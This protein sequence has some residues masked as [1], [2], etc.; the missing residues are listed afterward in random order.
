[1]SCKTSRTVCGISGIFRASAEAPSIDALERM[2]SV[3]EHRGPDGYGVYRDEAVAL[4][5]TRLS[6]IDLEGGAQP[7][8]NE[9]GTVWLTFNG[10]IFDYPELRA[11]LKAAGHVFRTQTDSE[12]IVHAYEEWGEQAW[13]R[14]DG[15]FAFALWDTRRGLLW[16]VRDPM[17]ILPLHYVEDPGGLAFGSEA[18]ALFAGGFAAPSFDIASLGQ[19]F[20]RWSVRAPHTM[21]EGV[22]MV[23]PGAA[24]RIERD[25]RIETRPY[26]ELDFTT[27]PELADV[28]ATEA[29]EALDAALT[30]S[31]RIRLRADVPVGSYL[32]GGLDSSVIAQRARAVSADRLETFAVRF[33]DPAFD[34]TLHQ[35]RMAELL[36]TEHHEV[37]CESRDVADALPEVIWH[38]ETPLVRTAPVPLYH[39]SGLVRDSGRRVVLTG[40]GADE[41]FA[42]Y[43]IFK[44]SRVRRFWARQPESRA[45][46]ALLSRVYP[47]VPHGRGA[48]MWQAFFKKGFEAVEDPLYSHRIRWSNTQ[49]ILRFLSD[50]A[51]A[52]IDLEREEARLQESLPKGFARWSPLARAQ[53]LEI[54]G[55]MRTYLLAA[56][57]DR[58]AMGHSVEV[59]YPFLD[60]EVIRLA[61]RLP[62]RTKLLGLR[63]KLVLRRL[64]QRSLPDSIWARPKQPYRAPM[65]APFF[66]PGRPEY[67]EALT[68]E[69]AILDSGLFDPAATA[70]LF[71][72][73]RASEGRNVSER[74]QMAIVG[75][76]TLQLLARAYG[77]ELAG[78]LEV[79]RRR[80]EAQPRLVF[81]DRLEVRAP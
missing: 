71:A 80:L 50:D 12:V 28:T 22:R 33:A 79:A 42:G 11:Q 59:R 72:K 39:L 29:V 64:A 52:A 18:K 60:P 9:D 2:L 54:D 13:S 77:P 37:V 5:H 55:F 66:G 70:A 30:E 32:S 57:G 43:N 1:M 16:L 58:V 65:V 27:P 25:G 41:L 53:W 67:V 49:A 3:L 68:R 24:L 56:Q 6:I 7:L 44:E 14:F 31:V 15:Q 35:R 62:D 61:A 40:E 63:D 78:R 34:E 48:R 46:P 36:G 38:A 26:F 76:L 20:S 74:E 81:V 75:L 23:P 73:A 19:V 8:C 51:R 4:G 10:E 45:R 17:G 21:F 69:A 47:Y